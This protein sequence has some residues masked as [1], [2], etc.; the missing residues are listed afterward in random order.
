M[1]GRHCRLFP[2]Y[3]SDCR[4]ARPLPLIQ[5][6]SSGEL[7]WLQPYPDRLLDELPTDDA[8]EPESLAVDAGDQRAGVR[9]RLP[10]PRDPPADRQDWTG[11]DEDAETR[12]LV[13]RFTDASVATDAGV[14]ATILRECGGLWMVHSSVSWSRWDGTRSLI[15]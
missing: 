14:L 10:A 13:R 8:D 9:D 1:P 4:N 2:L 5:A 12:E 6:I 11:S 3:S 7:L 15:N